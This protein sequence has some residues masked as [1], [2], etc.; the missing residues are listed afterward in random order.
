MADLIDKL[1][2]VQF[3]NL[4]VD[5]SYSVFSFL[6]NGSV[7]TKKKKLFMIVERAVNIN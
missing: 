1:N 7:C 4:L 5:Y 2:E 3:A 6:F